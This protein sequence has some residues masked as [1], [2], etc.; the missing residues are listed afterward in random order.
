M[1]IS[2]SLLRKTAITVFVLSMMV[3]SAFAQE[4]IKV[5]ITT[6]SFTGAKPGVRVEIGPYSTT[7]DSA[8]RGELTIAPGNYYARAT[9]S[10]AVVR[11]TSSQSAPMV[12]GTPQ[13]PL[14]AFKVGALKTANVTF[15]CGSQPPNSVHVKIA[16][17]RSCAGR[18]DDTVSKAEDVSVTIGD[19]AYKTDINGVIEV[20]LPQGTYPVNGSLRDTYLGFVARNG[21]MLAKNANGGYT[22]NLSDRVVNLEIRMFTC[23]ETGQGKP[24]A[25]I[26]EIGGSVRVKRGNTEELGSDGMRLRDGDT[27]VIN[28]KATLKWLD[29]NGIISF[30]SRSTII[31]IGPG[32]A[33]AGSVAPPKRSM[34][35]ILQGLGSFFIPKDDSD[36][37]PADF[38]ENGN[39]IIFRGSTH[40]VNVGVKGTVFSLGYD[41][42]TEVSTVAVQEGVVVVTPKYPGQKPFELRAGQRAEISPNGV[43]GPNAPAGQSG[44]T[45]RTNKS[46]YA[47]NER[48]E[49][50]FANAAGHPWDHIT[51]ARPVLDGDQSNVGSAAGSTKWKSYI[52]QERSGTK[53]F[54]GLAEGQYE[55]RYISWDNGNNRSTARI[56]FTVGIAPPPPATGGNP[57]S[58][59]NPP[60]AGSGDL[61]G[62]WVDDT[63]GGGIYR[64][65]Q[66]GNKLYWVVDAVSKQ[67]FANAYLG[68]INGNIIS[69]EWVDVPGSPTLSGGRL[70]LRIESNCKLVKV[71]SSNYYG[72]QV[73]TKQGSTCDVV[74]IVQKVIPKGA[75]KPKVEEIPDDLAAPTKNAGGIKKPETRKL[76]QPV[77]EEIPDDVVVGDTRKPSKPV[78]KDDPIQVEEI[79]DDHLAK[80]TTEVKPKTTTSS[81]P[82]PVKE[83]KP[84]AKNPGGGFWENLGKAV[85]T[86]IN[87]ANK[88]A[89]NQ[90][91]AG[92]QPGGV[93]NLVAVTVSPETPSRSGGVIWDYTTQGS[94]ATYALYNGD[95]AS[96]QWTRPPQQ[97][98]G[99]GFSVSISVWSNPAPRSRLHAVISVSGSGLNTDAPS[100]QQGASAHGENGSPASDQKSVR[101]TPQPNASEI[102]VVVAFHWSVRYTYKYRR[103]Q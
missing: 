19:S 28:G 45:V 63:R 53:T 59:G 87:E 1:F 62:L 98:D 74:G 2:K 48:I 21:N 92:N 66:I 31:R 44:P 23:D 100:D 96:F 82:P 73:W 33:P 94:S 55:A 65:R 9:T 38:D 41:D 18:P 93:W 78:N 46:A 26:M 16:T 76:D 50:T 88:P 47:P 12:G 58:T 103:A 99:N 13:V 49:V 72:A 91:P 30:D 95:K 102:E 85:G 37:D 11:V 34:L 84:K 81:N 51:I 57:P 32:D 15:V 54:D 69:G 24:R 8:G 27:V 14:L 20:D 39:R 68:E 22:V 71:S 60:A 75:E 7:T 43:N 56:S 4:T 29:G 67:S 40:G 35:E 61:S 86:A 89:G 10:C 17:T 101:F 42:Q 3:I 77:V 83:Q 6:D 52:D 97:I 70:L 79:P 25:V 80:P 64:L 5:F 36:Y 90:Q